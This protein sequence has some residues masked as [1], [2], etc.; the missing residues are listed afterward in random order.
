LCGGRSIRG[1]IKLINEAAHLIVGDKDSAA[2][3]A[4]F[5]Q[6]PEPQKTPPLKIVIGRA[7]QAEIGIPTLG[8]QGEEFRSC[9]RDSVSVVHVG[10][11][12]FIP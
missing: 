3:V 1:T 12:W 7:A 8:R 4:R 5:A 6:T 2:E 10:M 11:S 9:G